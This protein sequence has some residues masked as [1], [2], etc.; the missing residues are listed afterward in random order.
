[1]LWPAVKVAAPC[2]TWLLL[3]GLLFLLFI[4]LGTERPARITGYFRE[5]T[6]RCRYGGGLCPPLPQLL[7][8]PGGILPWDCAGWGCCSTSS[9]RCLRVC[10]H[11]EIS[12]SR[13]FK[14]ILSPRCMYSSAVR[15]CLPPQ[16]RSPHTLSAALQR[17]QL[18]TEGAPGSKAK[19]AGSQQLELC[20][21]ASTQEFRALNKSA[22]QTN[23][24]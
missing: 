12:W 18:R 22:L 21:S 16:C 17:G 4:R 24:H 5:L 9:F 20:L 19:P 10:T 3:S 13:D 23:S 14:I 1:M 8:C 6:A 15:A 11:R 2:T 7:L